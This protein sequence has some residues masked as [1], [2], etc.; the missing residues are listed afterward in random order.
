VHILVSFLS[1]A[2][3][4]CF[5]LMCRRTGHGNEARRVLPEINK[6]ALMDVVLQM[7]IGVDIRL[8]CIRDLSQHLRT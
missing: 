4:K 2:Q 8:Q 5:A 3:W 1:Y 7:K 6:P